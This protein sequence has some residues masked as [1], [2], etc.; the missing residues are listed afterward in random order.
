MNLKELQANEKGK[1]TFTPRYVKNIIEIFLN[2][3]KAFL[4]VREN[5]PDLIIMY[6]FSFTL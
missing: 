2:K 1:V 4:I 3:C 5:E 6:N